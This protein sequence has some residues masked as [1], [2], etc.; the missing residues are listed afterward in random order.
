MLLRQSLTYDQGKEM[1]QHKLLTT[2]LVMS[3]YFCDPHAPWQRG[4]NENT[5]GLVRLFPP[6][7]VD[8]SDVSQDEL[9]EISHLLNNRPRKTLGIQTPREV[10]IKE[11]KVPSRLQ[12][13]HLILK[14]TQYVIRWILIVTRT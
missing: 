5:N 8:L 13:L 9:D 3:I 7:G 11:L 10:Y 1:S 12:V 14:S 6:K 4:T 2:E